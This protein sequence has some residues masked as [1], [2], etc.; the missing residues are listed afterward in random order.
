[1]NSIDA[2]RR[3]NQIARTYYYGTESGFDHKSYLRD[4][5]RCLVDYFE[6]L[7]FESSNHKPYLFS[8]LTSKNEDQDRIEVVK[9]NDGP[10]YHFV[11][12]DIRNAL[13]PTIDQLLTEIQNKQSISL[14]TTLL[15]N[16]RKGKDLYLYSRN[17]YSKP[18]N[19]EGANPEAKISF[20]ALSELAFSKHD[21]S[22]DTF[23]NA[24]IKNGSIE[25]FKKKIDND[26]DD[27]A[28]C[29]TTQVAKLL[30]YYKRLENS[31]P[32]RLDNEFIV[33]FIRPSLIEFGYN[34]LLS[35][36]TD[37]HLSAEQLSFIYLLVYRIVNQMAIEKAKEVETLK[38]KKSYSLTS[39]SFKTVLST[40]IIPQTKS[41]A[42]A[43]HDSGTTCPS[44][45]D[46]VGSLLQQSEDLFR[47]TGIISLIDKVDKKTQFLKSGHADGLISPTPDPNVLS[48]SE[49]CSRYNQRNLNLDD[50][51][52]HGDGDSRLTISVFDEYFTAPLVTLFY[53]TLFENV[54]SH[55]KR[56]QNEIVLN[57]SE[58][59]RGWSFDNA[60]RARTVEVDRTKL[61]GNLSLFKTLIEETN[62]GSLTLDS[63]DHIFKVVYS[64]DGISNGT[65]QHL[66]D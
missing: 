11:N 60:T 8:A 1:M 38:R 27:P 63:G 52:I 28:E 10:G 41:L 31:L 17:S 58:T 42:K 65:N 43:I 53:K 35:L 13:E 37:K 64:S 59:E 33:H 26:E 57:V 30:W 2:V 34:I 54:V 55:A 12:A 62:S 29:E 50:I 5:F 22:F 49:Y 21:P 18:I 16:K 36:A 6:E 25:L 51:V 39:H 40:T 66:L 24:N 14:T 23:L 20:Y 44:I 46:A 15:R 56:M 61:T 48:I 9:L 19:P 45:N 4:C 7:K 47:L 3:V 32:A